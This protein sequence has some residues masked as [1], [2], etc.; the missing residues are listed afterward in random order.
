MMEKAE[1]KR[2]LYMF[3][4]HKWRVTNVSKFCPGPTED[5]KIDLEAIT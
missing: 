4:K 3:I 2:I 5:H 1:K